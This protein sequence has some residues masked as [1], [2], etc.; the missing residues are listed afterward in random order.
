MHCPYQTTRLHP[1]DHPLFQLL[2]L[3]YAMCLH[4]LGYLES[5]LHPSSSSFFHFHW[6]HLISGHHCSVP[7]FLLSNPLW[8]NCFSKTKPQS[9]LYPDCP[10][11]N[12]L[13][14]FTCSVT[15][16]KTL[17]HVLQILIPTKSRCFL[18][19]S[20]FSSFPWLCSQTYSSSFS[21]W[22]GLHV[23]LLQEFCLCWPL[24]LESAEQ[25][26]FCSSVLSQQI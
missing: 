12:T 9:W 17:E 25:I 10:K 22:N 6:K 5:S 15:K 4:S 26:N 14:V 19:V 13:L 21:S 8:S 3:I 24:Y 2:H 18:P 23:L 1:S 16:I 20:S 11:A 7:L